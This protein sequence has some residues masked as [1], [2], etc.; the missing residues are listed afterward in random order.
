MNV[1][2]KRAAVS[3]KKADEMCLP[4]QQEEEERRSKEREAQKRTAT[5]SP[6]E[7]PFANFFGGNPFLAG[8]AQQAPSSPAAPR[9][10]ED[11]QVL[12]F[13]WFASTFVGGKRA[14]GAQQR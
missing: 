14:A 11:A 8:S 12:D 2:L 3:R 1:G 10:K 5:L 7:Q 9:K 4:K 6:P 13:T